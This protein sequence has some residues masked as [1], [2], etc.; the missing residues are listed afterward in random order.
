MKK[1]S[2]VQENIKKLIKVNPKVLEHYNTL[3]LEY[4]RNYEN[5]SRPDSCTSPESITRNF[6]FLVTNG[7]IVI[8]KKNTRIRS[9]NEKQYREEFAHTY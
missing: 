6:R 7:E 2:T 4:W 9:D 8:T 5:L 3:V 1:P